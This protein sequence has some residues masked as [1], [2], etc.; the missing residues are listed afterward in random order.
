MYRIKA[1]YNIRNKILGG[2]RSE[3]K[4]TNMY[5]DQMNCNEY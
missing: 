3:N 1:E 2:R 4:D 5:V